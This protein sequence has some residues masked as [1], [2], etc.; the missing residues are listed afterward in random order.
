MPP[1]MPLSIRAEAPTRKARA[2]PAP[3]TVKCEA[4]FLMRIKGS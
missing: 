1:T 4:Y 3:K 2:Q